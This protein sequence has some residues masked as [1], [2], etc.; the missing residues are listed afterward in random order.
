MDNQT[1]LKEALAKA[2]GEIGIEIAPESIPLVESKEKAHGDYASPIAMKK[3][4]EA[5]RNPVELANDI[6]SR[7]PTDLVEHCEVAGPGFINFF[8]KKED[9]ESVVSKIFEEGPHFGDGAKKNRKIDVEFVSANPTGDLHLGH[10][11]GAALGDA[12]ASLLQKAGYD[13]TREYYVNDC[14]NQVRHLGLSL[15]ARY[16][17][18]FGYPLELGDDDYHGEDLI[19]IAQ[20]IKDQKGDSLLAGTDEDL[21]FFSRYGVDRELSKIKKD[22]SD[23]GVHFDVFTYE[24][25]IRK[26]G[27]IEE[28][29]AFFKEKG[30]AYEQ[31]GALFLKT[32]AYLDDKDR[33]IVKK[34]GTYT[35]FMPDIAYHYDKLSR[36]FDLLV[37]MLGADHHGYLARMK[38][39]LMMKG[40]PENVL[41]FGLYQIVRV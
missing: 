14:G 12:T 3:A 36:G 13:V 16:K 33:P 7:L 34:D 26:S 2:F 25:D 41:E 31:D 39:A 11:R 9:L 4:K 28:A 18:L 27:K 32:S 21:A 5:K 20:E 37:D 17:E 10:T 6:A 19:A 40:Y 23:F 35:Y 22:L 15:Y 38:S 24:S 30:L 1:R 29:I 8:L